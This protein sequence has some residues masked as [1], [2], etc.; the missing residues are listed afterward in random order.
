MGGDI[1][2]ESKPGEGAEFIVTLPS[3]HAGKSQPTV[4]PTV[5]MLAR[6][7]RAIEMLTHELGPEARFSATTDP[8][9]AAALARRESPD[10]VLLDACAPEHSAWRALSSLQPD[11]VLDGTRVVLIAQ[12]RQSMNGVELGRFSILTKPIY[13]ERASDAIAAHIEGSD[14]CQ[15]IV[16]DEDPHVRQILTDA[17]TATG[18]NVIAAADGS[19][20]IRLASTR[21]P[22]VIILSLTLRGSNGVTTL[23]NL[24]AN[25]T[26]SDIPVVMLVPRELTVEQMVQLQDAVE[27][28]TASGEVPSK[29]LAETIRKAL[30]AERL[31]IGGMEP[32]ES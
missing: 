31:P 24:R 17:L 2:V 28:L 26:L 18:C 27:T 15:V 25:P 1:R 6:S 12:E 7:E 3:A 16:A 11:S 9:M 29:P 32:V 21:K 8:S 10:I 30:A 23:A 13:V 20:A 14:N 19:E 4:G 22:N 5:V